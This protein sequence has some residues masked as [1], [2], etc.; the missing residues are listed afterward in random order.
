MYKPKHILL[1]IFIILAVIINIM[2]IPAQ[3]AN[4]ILDDSIGTAGYVTDEASLTATEYAADETATATDSIPMLHDLSPY[5]FSVSPSGTYVNQV[6]TGTGSYFSETHNLLNC[7]GPNAAGLAA[8]CIEPSK[9]AP[10]SATPYTEIGMTDSSSST[11][12]DKAGAAAVNMYGYGGLSSVNNDIIGL[13]EANSNMGGTYGIYVLDGTAYTGILVNG[14]FFKMSSTEAHALTAAVI[15]KLNG[16][17]I[18]AI[19]GSR[20]SNDSQ[21]AEASE[22]LYSLGSYAR[23]NTNVNG[24]DSTNAFLSAYTVPSQEILIKLKDSSGNWVELPADSKNQDFDWSAYTFEG[25]ISYQVTYKAFRCESKLIYSPG[26]AGNSGNISYNHEAALSFPAYP[27]SNGYYD[28]ISFSEGEKNNI[29][30]NIDYGKLSSTPRQTIRLGVIDSAYGGFPPCD[31]VEFYQ[32]AT[33]TVSASDISKGKTLDLNINIPTAAGHTPYYGD[34]DGIDGCYAASR[35]FTAQYY[36][37]IA[38]ASPNNSLTAKSQQLFAKQQTGS[39]K[40][41]KCSALPEATDGNT[42]YSLKLATYGIYESM[43]DAGNQTNPVATITTNETGEASVSNIPFGTYYISE[44]NAPQTY[45]L[46]KSIYTIDVPSATPVSINVSDTPVSSFPGLLLYKQNDSKKPVSGAEFEVCFYKLYSEPEPSELGYIP[47]KTWHFKSDDNGY[48]FMDEAHL[49]SGDSFYTNASGDIILPLGTLTIRETKAPEGYI[50]DSTIRAYKITGNEC[51]T[52]ETLPAEYIFTNSIAKQAFQIIKY[53]ETM[54]GDIPLANA[55]FMACRISDLNIDEN[56]K[57]IWNNDKAV[58][59]TDDGNRELFTDENG[60]A[61]STPIEYGTYLVKETTVPN[62]YLPIDD[63]IVEINCNSDTPQEIRYFTDDSFK[64]YIKICKY[65]ISTGNLI[66][67]NPATFSI[68]SYDTEEYVM[69]D[70]TTDSDGILK[71]SSP[72]FPGR[73]GICETS[74]PDGYYNQTPDSFYDF[75]ISANNAYESCIDKDCPDKNAAHITISLYNTPVTGQIEIYKTGDTR[76]WNT[77]DN[78]F[79]TDSIPLPD[80]TFDIIAAENIYFSDNSGTLIHEKDA[81]IETISTD[82]NG[83]A[84]SSDT[85]LPGK[86]IIRENTPKGYKPIDDIEITLALDGTLIETS[87]GNV[88]NKHILETL[89]IHNEL[90]IP[91]LTTSARD[92]TTN[93]NTGTLNNNANIIDEIKYTNLIEGDKYTIQG[94]IMNPATSKPYV[95][96]ENEITGQTDFVCESANGSVDVEFNLDSTELAGKSIVLYEVLYHNDQIVAV[97]TD[98]NN[99]EQTITYPDNPPDTPKTGDT[100]AVLPYIILGFITLITFISVIIKKNH[101]SNNKMNL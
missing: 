74:C 61:L 22:Y 54:D 41:N 87:S 43:D 66:K 91:E 39:I 62:N 46:D 92:T 94:I 90:L 55:G 69:T 33:I 64:A 10:S 37:D 7:T 60:Y 34:G 40:L 23:F 81:L 21:V 82:K 17:R 25:K 45:L 20:L 14:T 83:H 26:S 52:P 29:N 31:G 24:W 70:L 67:N 100:Y 35:F 8:Y 18:S 27:S 49:T 42:C 56:G 86:Y 57:Y 9:N 47:D 1:S 78:D 53:G 58:I 88:L 48:V 15:H 11:T 75:E 13:P 95:I 96:N 84:I 44:L 59:L 89:Y 16:S 6:L 50:T 93:T 28:Y 73:Y 19:T 85:L 97:H 76:E 65:D 32:T 68:W 2:I 3:A 36:Q 51:Y 12:A 30:V 99:K 38:V 4:N 63:F 5:N 72:L 98:I 80:I 79:V 77:S 101:K 71:T